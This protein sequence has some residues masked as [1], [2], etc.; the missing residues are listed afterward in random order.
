VTNLKNGRSAQ[1]KINDRGPAVRGRSLDLSPAAA[2]K[3]GLTKSGVAR[4][5]ITPVSDRSATTSYHSPRRWVTRRVE[6][7]SVLP[8]N[9]RKVAFSGTAKQL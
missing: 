5:E 8:E 1:V 4:V 3:I 9:Y 6:A 2:Q 7:L